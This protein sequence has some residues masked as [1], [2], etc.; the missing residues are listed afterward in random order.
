MKPS[1]FL[2]LFSL[3]MSSL[4][5]TQ[6]NKE[7]DNEDTAPAAVAARSFEGLLFSATN[8]F[9]S[10]DGSMTVPVNQSLAQPMVENI[11]FTFIYSEGQPGFFDPIARSQEWAWTDSQLPW[12]S[13]G[14]ETR[15]YTTSLTK[16]NFD[17]AKA[18]Q[19]RIAGFIAQSSS[20]LAPH[21]IYPT[22]SCIGGRQTTGTV[23]LT[24]GKVFGFE[25]VASGKQGLLF[26]RNDQIDPSWPNIGLSETTKVDIIIEK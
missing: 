6:C 21:S 2:V 24:R 25:N 17:A 22:G 3:S 10:T 15:F 7:D 12:L 8:A 20:V 11:D 23:L 19:S 9:F 5:F 26:I 4:L 13:E 14:V 1:R 16:A 18:D